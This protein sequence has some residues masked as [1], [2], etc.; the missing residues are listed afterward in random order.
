MF[1]VEGC[2]FVAALEVPVELLGACPLLFTV[3]VELV[4]AVLGMTI[5]F[6]GHNM[7]SSTAATITVAIIAAS[8]ANCLCFLNQR[9][10]AI[11]FFL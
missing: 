1:G 5:F 9:F 8:S 7:I 10:M 3:D 11:Y 4:G 6:F 2:V